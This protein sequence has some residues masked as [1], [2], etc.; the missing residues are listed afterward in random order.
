MAKFDETPIVK[1]PAVEGLLVPPPLREHIAREVRCWPS[2]EKDTHKI[3]LPAT[4]V[5][6]WQEKAIQKFAELLDKN[7]A[8][9]V[10]MDICVRCG[11]CTDKCQF[12][13]GTGD[14]QNFP[15]A[16]AELMRKVYR[17]YFTP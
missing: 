9:R 12:F 2:K 17:R 4:L 6:D 1:D 10:Y 11:A 16:R 8:L 3:N 5:P 7:K 14:P 13:L 15:V